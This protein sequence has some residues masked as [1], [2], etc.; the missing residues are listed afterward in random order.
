MVDV[1]AARSPARRSATRRA[2][3]AGSCSPR[4]SRSSTTTRELDPDEKRHLRYE[5]LHGWE[6]VDDT[7]RLCAMNLLLHGIGTP[8]EH[9]SPIRSTT[10]SRADPGDA[11]RRGR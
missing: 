6:I 10:R 9:E 4:T 1:H 7:A 5:A 11:L 2:A 8:S 3:P